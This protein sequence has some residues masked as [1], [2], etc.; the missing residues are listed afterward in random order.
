M[1]E[2]DLIPQD[3]HNRLRMGRLMRGF[4]VATIGLILVTA[5]ASATLG[6]LNE[7]DSKIV[8]SLEQKK[9]AAT[10]QRL[11]LNDLLARSRRL[12][13]QL[14]V[15][16]RLRGGAAA[17][18]MFVAVDRALDGE[19]VWFTHWAFRRAGKT[20]PQAPKTVN[21]G[22]FIVIP[23]GKGP[24]AAPA[25]QI[26]THME[27]RG[28]AVDHAALS[29]FV[30]RLL[31]QPQIGDVRVLNTHKREFASSSVVEYSLA[32]TI[33]SNQVDT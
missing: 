4:G 14:D 28:Q 26:A 32:I 3:Y 24:G 2:I 27:I 17:Q 19:T 29:Q 18:D 20:A 7:R 10:Q 9:A 33:D 15:L 25:W 11:V 30:R 5:S 1:S 6:Y 8:A 31:N 12:K 16:E 13:D 23:R 22:Y 21:K